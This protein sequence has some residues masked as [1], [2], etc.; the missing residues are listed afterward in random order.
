MV[1]EITEAR[2]VAS[3]A[4]GE[5]SGEGCGGACCGE[6]GWR[7]GAHRFVPGVGRLHELGGG[8]VGARC[9]RA[10]MVKGGEIGDFG[11]G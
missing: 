8:R 6:G 10:C 3:G 7:R 5:G 1:V 11:G 9:R 4:G 2:A